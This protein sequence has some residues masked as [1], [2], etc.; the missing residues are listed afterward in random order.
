M[1]SP[2]PSRATAVVTVSYNSSGELGG[3][4]DSVDGG[5]LAPHTYIADNLSADLEATRAI[6]AVHDATVV[7]VGENRGYGG[8]VN[9]ATAALPDEV[10]YILV[11]NPDVRLS[12]DTVR[13]L[14]QAMEDRPE[15]G[16]VG[17]R[18]LNVDGTPYPSARSFPSL[19]TGVGHAVFFSLWPRNP[20][21][22]RY[23]SHKD[24]SLEPR[25][26]DWLSG[27]C[28]L[29]RRTAFDQLGGFDEGYFMYFEDVDLGYRLAKAG[30]KRLF[31]P[32]TSV[33]HSGAH[34]TTTESAKMIRAHHDS[35][36]RYLSRKYSGPLLAPL[37][38]VL[39]LGLDLRATYL[40]RRG[41]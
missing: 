35:A 41:A 38:W 32:T 8:A 39:R 23:L 16:A 17:P 9:A 3:F 4:L 28:M 40:T 7:E 30:W 33:V 14:V 12:P 36:Y 19:R 18:V 26:V 21:S 34:S 27:S 10:R 1:S 11:S 25:T 37:R 31:L 2:V 29:V 13:V 22:R 20:W 24:G 15:L 5:E 6:A